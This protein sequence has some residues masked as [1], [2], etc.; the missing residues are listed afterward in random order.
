MKKFIFTYGLAIMLSPLFAQSKIEVKEQTEDI[1]GASHNA[2]VVKI[3]QCKEEDVMKEWKSIMKGY[4]AKISW[5][6]EM[7]ADNASIKD[8]SDNTVD[9]HSKAEATPEGD[10][11]FIAGF[12]LGGAYLSSTQHPKEF[13]AAKRIV[14]DF[15]KDLSEKGFKQRIKLE[16][17]ALGALTLQKDFTI[18]ENE[19]LQRDIENFKEKVAKAEEKIKANTEALKLKEQEITGQ[20]KLLESIIKNSDLR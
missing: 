1:G 3:F 18:K 2:L 13:K 10:I 16:E 20:Q 15:A 6:K 7:F 5:K 8:V 4:D 17:K 14:A 11:N 12:D 9:V 19:N